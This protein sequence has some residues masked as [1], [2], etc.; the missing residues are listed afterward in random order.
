MGGEKG[1][2]ERE[3]TRWLRKTTRRDG[4]G[5][6]G[7]RRRVRSA[8]GAVGRAGRAE[9]EQGCTPRAPAR[10]SPG[11]GSDGVPEN[12]GGA[13]PGGVQA[14]QEAERAPGAPRPFGRRLWKVGP[15]ARPVPPAP[16]LGTSLCLHS[17]VPESGRKVPAACPVL[18][19][20][21]ALTSAGWAADF[22]ALCRDL[23][24]RKS[25]AKD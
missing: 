13:A 9:S 7:R 11:G 18:G 22:E 10:P 25:R 16:S 14:A 21:R 2:R 23:P 3:G 17:S 19:G 24:G 15:G 20:Q 12:P 8:P 5:F 4:A 6:G 1:I